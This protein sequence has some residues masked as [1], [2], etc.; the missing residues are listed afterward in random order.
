VAFRSVQPASD[1]IATKHRAETRL[2]LAD[3]LL[4]EF[5]VFVAWVGR[6]VPTGEKA[7]R[8]D[9][10][11]KRTAHVP[12]SRDAT[13]KASRNSGD[14]VGLDA[15]ALRDSL[16]NAFGT[17]KA[18]VEKLGSAFGDIIRFEVHDAIVDRFLS[19]VRGFGRGW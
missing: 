7:E 3:Y 18:L 2:E 17:A 1:E 11:G 6:T 4:D 19:I 14:Q 12:G 10:A 15:A 8:H 13:A 9:S 16:Q 5:A